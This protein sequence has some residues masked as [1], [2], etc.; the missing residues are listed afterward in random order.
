MVKKVLPLVIAILLLLGCNKSNSSI[1]NTGEYKTNKHI[2]NES[3]ESIAT[4]GEYTAIYSEIASSWKL[5]Q[6]GMSM[7]WSANYVIMQDNTLWSWSINRHIER[8]NRLPQKIMDD[9]VTVETGFS[10]TLVIRSDGSLWGWGG[11]SRGE[12]GDG[13]TRRVSFPTK[14]MDDAISLA[15]GARTS[16]AVKAD[17]SLWAWGENYRG[18]LG[19]GML[20]TWCS[21]DNIFISESYLN[22]TEIMD[23]VIFV[24]SGVFHNMAI[25]SDGSLWVWGKNSYGVIGNG[26]KTTIVDFILTEDNDVTRPMKVMENIVCAAAGWNTSFAIDF[27]G[28]LWG[29]GNNSFGQLGDGTTTNRLAPVKIMEDVI[30]VSAGFA[31]TLALKSDGSLWAWGENRF[32]EIG[33]GTE[34]IRLE[35]VEIMSNVIFIETGLSAGPTDYDFDGTSTSAGRSFAIRTNGSLWGWGLMHHGENGKSLI[36]IEITYDMLMP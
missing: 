9:V 33:D 28:V 25:K 4:G 20:S 27:N 34:E 24:A 13:T 7:N 36:P 31:H 12:V 8:F 17:G 6:V 16:F 29:W 2:N 21:L 30:S 3:Q 19:S 22:P 15:A 26:K 11:N 32:G 1:E 23:N 5:G 35:P 14:I 18:S 10:H